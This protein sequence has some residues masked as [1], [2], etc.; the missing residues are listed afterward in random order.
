M[1]DVNVFCI[2]SKTAEKQHGI[3]AT[4]LLLKF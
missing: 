2:S 1:V 3:I 4:N